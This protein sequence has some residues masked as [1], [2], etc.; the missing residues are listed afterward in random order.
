MP[1]IAGEEAFYGT[2]HFRLDE[3]D[4]PVRV[5]GVSYTIKG[6][7]VYDAAD[8]YRMSERKVIKTDR[9]CPMNCSFCSV[10]AFNGRKYR[11]RP[12]NEVLD[13]IESIPQSMLFFVDDNI[14]GHGRGAE[15]G[16]DRVELRFR[17]G[18][19]LTRCLDEEIEQQRLVSLLPG[20]QETAAA[21]RC[22]HGFDDA[23]GCKGRQ[24]RIECIA[25]RIVHAHAGLGGLRMTCRDGAFHAGP[26][27]AITW[28]P[29]PKMANRS[30]RSRRF[31]ARSATACW[32]SLT[33]CSL[34]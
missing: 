3:N 31:A 6:G 33:R 27:F 21:K 32:L 15:V 24:H 10:T 1:S 23:G 26:G 25:A 18:T 19:P 4:R 16:D 28:C 7:V 14:I 13:E 9:G 5:G 2:G 30:G 11:Q 34:A 22:E 29:V 20:E 8:F 12:V 17:F